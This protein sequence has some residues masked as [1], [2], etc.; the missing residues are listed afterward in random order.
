MTKSVRESFARQPEPGGPVAVALY[1]WPASRD[2]LDIRDT[3][4]YGLDAAP[5]RPVRPR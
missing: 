1:E 3:T 2:L 4:A 5:A